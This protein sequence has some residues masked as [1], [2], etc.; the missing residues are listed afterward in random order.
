M[1]KLINFLT[2]SR[3]FLAPILFFL[4]AYL[5]YFGWA[6][7]L[8]ILASLSDYL[9]GHLARKYDLTSMLGEVL[10]PIADKILIIFCLIG[11]SLHLNSLFIGGL[12]C[13]ILTREVW[14]S[15]LRDINSRAN[16]TGATQ[17]TFLAKIKTASQLF[18]ISSYFIGLYLNNWLII[19]LSD[20]IL[21]I[22]AII[23]IKT[24]IDYTVKTF[25]RINE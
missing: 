21:I 10:D 6:F 7:V 12:T 18:S 20:F 5:N 1:K 4:V 22:A 15:A 24:G 8:L 13:I 23:T 16:N 17:V 25:Y 11:I 14:V 3:I 19:F 9:D 2:L